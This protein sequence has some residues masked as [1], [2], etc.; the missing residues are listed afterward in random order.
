MITFEINKTKMDKNI[1]ADVVFLEKK[2]NII[3]KLINYTYEACPCKPEYH[4]RTISVFNI[5]DF[6]KHI[7]EERLL[8]NFWINYIEKNFSEESLQV[9]SNMCKYYDEGL[10]YSQSY[11]N[12][13]T[14]TF[15]AVAVDMIQK[16]ND[17][18]L[19]T[20]LE[21][22][23]DFLQARMDAEEVDRLYRKYFKFIGYHFIRMDKNNYCIA[24]DTF[25]FGYIWDLWRGSNFYSVTKI[26]DGVTV[27]TRNYYFP[28]T[29]DFIKTIEKM[30]YSKDNKV[31]LMDSKDAHELGCIGYCNFI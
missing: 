8:R 13:L 18:N 31:N 10:S 23:R 9:V 16:F 12:Y 25:D 27:W 6:C 20:L 7:G 21:A 2:K 11:A 15:E 19:A 5:I 1:N 30:G 22:I 26:E 29:K 3:E 17:E 28:S 4:F 14:W 24:L